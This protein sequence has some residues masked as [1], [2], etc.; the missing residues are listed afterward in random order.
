VEGSGG[1]QEVAASNRERI[2]ALENELAR[3]RTRQHE[4]SE[5]VAIIRY[6]ADQVRELGEDVK[7]LTTQVTALA[8]RAIERPTPAGFSAI[9]SWLA[10]GVAILTLVLVTAR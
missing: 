7:A 10:L 3:L 4:L 5:Q 9:A 2:V 8:R 1:W 6:L